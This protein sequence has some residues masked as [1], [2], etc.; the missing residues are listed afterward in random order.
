MDYQIR[1][2]ETIDIDTL[3]KINEL[4]IPAVNSITKT[5]FEWFYKN[6][7]Y[8]KLI[9]SVEKE[10]QG[11]LLTLDSSLDYESLNYKWFQERYD[12]FAYIDRIAIL[13]K[14]KRNGLGRKLYMDLE[15]SIKS[16]YK[17]IACEYNLRPMNY[18]SEKFHISIGYQRAGNL[19]TQKGAKEVS[20]M[21]KNI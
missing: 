19:I 14:H 15:K 8:F 16:D 9:Q 20:L 18:E 12:D 10:V 11:F 7:L 3:I 13:E 2:V 6:S 1:N 5:Q 17:M 21:I 4:S